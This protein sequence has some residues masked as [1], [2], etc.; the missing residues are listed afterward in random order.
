MPVLSPG[1]QAL[2]FRA[3]LLLACALTLYFALSPKP[4]ELFLDQFGDKFEHSLAFA[5]LMMLASGAFPAAGL[6]RIVER[7]SFLG[8]LIEVV[9]GTP[10]IQRDCDIADWLFDTL[11]IMITAA[12]IAR[13]RHR[14]AAR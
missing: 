8:A 13:I 3:A 5:V 11:A 2:I 12:I 6:L 1:R 9:Q 7:L 14:Y 10:G 4:P